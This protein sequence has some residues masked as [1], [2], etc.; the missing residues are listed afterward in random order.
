[1]RE[2]LTVKNLSVIYKVEERKIYAL[3]EVSFS[4]KEGEILGVV[5]E[6]GSGKTTLGLSILSLLDEK[7]YTSGKIIFEGRDIFSLS[8]QDLLCIRGRKIGLIFQEPAASFNPVLTIGYQ[9]REILR[10]KLNLKEK[11]LV[12][13]I[14]HDSF[15]RVKLVEE[16]RILRSYPHTLSGGQLQRIAIAFSIALSPLILIADEPTSNLDITVESQ[17]IHLFLRLKEELN[18][19]VIFI[20]HNL[21]LARVIC[22]RICVLYEGEMKEIREKEALFREPKDPYTKELI[23]AFKRLE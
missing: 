2:I 18:L 13:Q 1:M 20:T 4:L 7:A 22:D 19:S 5:G 16:E 11:N 3:K 9:F 14:I 15:K 6:S 23:E 21:D 12:S 10:E 8:E 17:I